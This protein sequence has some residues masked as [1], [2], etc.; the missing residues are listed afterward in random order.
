MTQ[1]PI[2][3]SSFTWIYRNLKWYR[4]ERNIHPDDVVITEVDFDDGY[5][6]TYYNLDGT[7]DNVRYDA[8]CSIDETIYSHEP[9]RSP[10][11]QPSEFTRPL[12]LSNELCEFLDIPLLSNKSRSYVTKKICKY[13][14]DHGLMDKYNIHGDE[15]LIKLFPN[16]KENNDLTTLNLQK[17]LRPHY[18]DELTQSKLRRL[19]L[20]KRIKQELME[21]VW[22]PDRLQ[23]IIA[24]NHG[25]HWSHEEKIYTDLNFNSMADIL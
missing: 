24:R 5:T 13:A 25:H 7:I 21:V 12:I 1:F 10:E 2:P 18:S 23:R 17:Y 3:D 14:K 11:S 8:T 20:N 15:R 22:H 4:F 16:L 6:E 9:S 19:H